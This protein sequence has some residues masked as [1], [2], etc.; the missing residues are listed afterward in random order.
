VFFEPG[1]DHW[2]GAVPNR[3]ITSDAMLEVDDDGTSAT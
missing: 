2:H 3:F 1:Q